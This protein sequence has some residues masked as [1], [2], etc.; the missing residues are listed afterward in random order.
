MSARCWA[1]TSRNA[2][3]SRLSVSPTLTATEARLFSL[4]RLIAPYLPNATLDT[5][6]PV[7]NISTEPP[8]YLLG[9]D[10]EAVSQYPFPQH[11]QQV[12]TPRHGQH[13]RLR[14]MHRRPIHDKS[15]QRYEFIERIP[16]RVERRALTPTPQRCRRGAPPDRRR[17]AVVPPDRRI[18]PAATGLRA[19][20]PA[21]PGAPD[22]PPWAR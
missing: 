20:V 4:G 12:S 21:R 22:Q 5:P 10:P 15:S 3:R 2:R 6:G 17:P 7:T 13:T 19:P 1:D 9:L 16:Y 8:G 11:C 18:G 14:P